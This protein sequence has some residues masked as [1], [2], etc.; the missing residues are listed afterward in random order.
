MQDF[1]FY[2]PWFSLLLL[3][4]VILL[5]FHKRVLTKIR[6]FIANRSVFQSLPLSTKQYFA[7]LVPSLYALAWVFLTLALMRPQVKEFSDRVQEGA[8]LMVLIDRSSSMQNYLGSSY[9]SRLDSA[10]E[11]FL[12]I[13][14]QNPSRAI[15]LITFAKY[16]QTISPLTFSHQP[17]TQLIDYIDFA[18]ED[19]D[20]TAIGDAIALASARLLEAFTNQK[21]IDLENTDLAGIKDEQDKEGVMIIITDGESNVGLSPL[22][23]AEIAKQWNLRIYAI[24]MT[25]NSNFLSQF[26]S[27]FGDIQNKVLEEI[28]VETDGKFFSA[29]SKDELLEAYKTISELE[30]NNIKTSN[31]EIIVIEKYS[32]FLLWAF[33]SLLLGWLLSH[34]IFRRAL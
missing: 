13:V 3:L 8:P 19:E 7:W 34:T 2:Y 5:L 4:P 6:I 11:V 16:V 14:K 26:G 21:N 17:L 1:N 31:Q 22:K 18:E 25:D 10:K 29:Q 28:T 33:L 20:G 23:A 30:L 9:R 32:N 24:N 12:D 15:G 27:L